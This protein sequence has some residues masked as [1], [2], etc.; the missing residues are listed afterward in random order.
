MARRG[1]D[2]KTEQASRRAGRCSSSSGCKRCPTLRAAVPDI[3][4]TAITP[5]ERGCDS[6]P[7]PSPPWV[8]PPRELL[9]AVDPAAEPREPQT[10]SRRAAGRRAL[11]GS[12]SQ[13][14]VGQVGLAARAQ[15]PDPAS[16]SSLAPSVLA[17]PACEASH[18]ASSAAV[19]CW[20]RHAAGR[21]P[22]LGPLARWRWRSLAGLDRPKSQLSPA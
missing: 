12:R 17:P 9:A 20:A 19:L 2:D 3:P 4:S 5:L 6:L 21:H 7:L 11:L 18:P 10:Q 8:R 22:P 15:L 14:Q 16:S 13:A 1:G